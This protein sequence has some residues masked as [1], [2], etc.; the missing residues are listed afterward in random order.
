MTTTYPQI[1]ARLSI[2][3]YAQVPDGFSITLKDT[4]TGQLFE[5]NGDESF[6]IELLSGSVKKYLLTAV[7]KPTAVDENESQEPSAFG[8]TGISP[9]PF[10]PATT[11]NYVM[12]SSDNVT[13]RIYNLGGQLVETLADTHMSAGAH[14]VVWDVA[15]QASGVYIVVVE[16]GGLKD[17]RKITL[18]K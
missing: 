7:M 17:T 2:T 11:I 4:E 9:N 8:I 1:G 5:L 15:G 16:S 13:I 6:D 3:E 10:N 12:E 18:M 14:S